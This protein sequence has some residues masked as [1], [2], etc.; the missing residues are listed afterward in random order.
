MTNPITKAVLLDFGGTLFSYASS[1][2]GRVKRAKLLAET[3]GHDD[4]DAVFEALHLGMREAFR[5]ANEGPFYLHF[6][7]AIQGY[8]NA[9]S[10]I[11]V[12]WSETEGRAMAER[13]AH[14]S[15]EGITP[16]PGMRE[17][18]DTL[19]ERGIHLGGVSNADDFQLD[20]MVDALGV[21]DVFHHL[22]SSETARSCKP[23]A[24]IFNQAL[25]EAGCA[26]EEVI[27]VG[28]TPD[29]DIVG[30]EA[31]GMRPVL[32]EET[33]EIAIDRG[34][35]KPGQLTIKELPELLDLI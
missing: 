3:L 13:V 12:E 11:G 32:I 31:V 25:A 16:R 6:D 4:D 27:F 10:A 18:L 28:D 23:D 14:M 17:T 26:P 8:R 7:V 19:R 2:G 30:A 1:A 35:P 24:A 33:T 34:K 15:F 22:L 9:A 5:V 20:A 29:A 21:R